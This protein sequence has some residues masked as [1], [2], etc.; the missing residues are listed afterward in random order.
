MTATSRTERLRSVLLANRSILSI[1]AVALAVRFA[2][3]ALQGPTAMDWD[4]ANYARIAQNLHDGLG[5]VTLRGVPNVLHAPLYPLLVAALL[6]I[7]QSP[8]VAGIVLSMVSGTLFVVLVYRVTAAIA[9]ARVALIAGA[10]AALHPYMIDASIVPL[11]E[12]LFLTLTFAGLDALLRGL[13]RQSSRGLALAG[14]CFGGAYITREEGLAY[15]VIAAIAV[16][17]VVLHVR[18]P[19]RTAAVQLAALL[20]PFM[21]CAAPYIAFLSHET[22]HL[23]LEAKSVSNY[24]IAIPMSRGS[25]Y[26]AA[27]DAIGPHLEDVGVELGPSYPFSGARVPLPSVLARLQ[28]ALRAAPHHA[29]DLVR[30]LGAKRNG[31]PLFLAF[32]LI[33]TVSQLRSRSASYGVILAAALLAEFAALLSIY[34]FWDRYADPFVALLLPWTAYGIVCVARWIGRAF[35]VV[36]STRLLAVGSTLAVVV[37]TLWFMSTVTELRGNAVDPVPFRDAGAWI[38]AHGPRNPV[39]MAVDP[40][41]AYYGGGTWRALP[42]TNAPT[43]LRYI[44]SRAPAYVVVGTVFSDR[45]YLP[46]WVFGRIPDAAAHKVFEERSNRNV[47]IVYSWSSSTRNPGQ[48]ARVESPP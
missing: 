4:A 24:G 46:A 10:L 19:F 32:A 47:I 15:V 45:P 31:S 6:F 30:V 42:D 23:S 22:G 36:F 35:A 39:V 37:G 13:Q 28:L 14:L 18:T 26:I 27:A 20:M 29:A 34:H 8:V 25:T 41:T 12:A 48:T 11:S 17:V 43:A 16:I 38:A 2:A 40:L 3:L 1:A 5:N 44:A 33:G 21:L 7:V 9:G